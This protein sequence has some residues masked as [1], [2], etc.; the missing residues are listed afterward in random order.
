M[1]CTAYM[2]KSTVMLECNLHSALYNLVVWLSYY[3]K[4]PSKSRITSPENTIG[5]Q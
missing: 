2:V 4:L 1:Q 5:I 3:P